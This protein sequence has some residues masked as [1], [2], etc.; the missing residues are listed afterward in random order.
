MDAFR[1]LERTRNP[2]R[3][4]IVLTDGQRF[5]WRPGESGRWALVRDLHRR[6]PFPP[7]VWS[8][9][10]GGAESS[11]MP[12]ASI[13][14]LSVTRTMVTPGLPLTVT[15]SVENAGNAPLTRTAELLIDG[16][17]VAGSAQVA[18][19]IPAGGRT[20]L[21]FATTINTP[22]SHLLTVRLD[23]VDALPGDDESDIP[24]EVAP[25][26]PVLLVDGEP[27]PQPLS[28]ETDFLRAALAPTG[29]E[30]PQVTARVIAPRNS[31]PTRSE[32]R[33]SSYSPTW[34][35]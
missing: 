21:S 24:I 11:E 32:V 13:G 6:L 8:I 22:G 9:G 10:F 28:G 23:G 26:I 3:T 33:R 16:R 31:E 27:S 30:T 4:I 25:A 35:G 15:T 12:N 29:D 2:G 14:P 5:A 18:G 7:A 17:P 34:I 20:P 1:I 19:P